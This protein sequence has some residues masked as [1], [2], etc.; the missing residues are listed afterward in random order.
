MLL[1][2]KRKK[3]CCFGKNFQAM[4][5]GVLNFSFLFKHY[6]YRPKLSETNSTFLFDGT[7]TDKVRASRA[8]FKPINLLF[9]IIFIL[10]IY[11]WIKKFENQLKSCHI[12]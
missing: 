7:Q 2:Q 9:Y 5:H 12:F 3:S 10:R 4:D 8:L 6:F 1:P 11:K